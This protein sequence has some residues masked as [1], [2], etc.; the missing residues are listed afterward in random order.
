VIIHDLRIEYGGLVAQIDHLLINRFLDFYV[1]ETK[2][3]SQGVKVTERGEFLAVY[4]NRYVAIESPIEQNRRHI[5]VLEDFLVGESILPKRLGFTLRPRFLSYIL[6]S[7]KSRVIRP[8]AK[9]FNTDMLIKAD[10]FYRQT[11]DNLDNESLIESVGSAAK[12]ISR[13][14]LREVGERITGFHQPIAPDYYSK[15]GVSQVQDTQVPAPKLDR[16]PSTEVMQSKYY[17]FKC[18]CNISAKVASFCFGH[19][20]RFKG[21]AY[22]FECQKLFAR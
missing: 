2:H 7:P 19:K 18:R 4:R 12:I 20:N 6:F 22:C 11:R 9:A 14:S 1:L 13:E 8:K 3:Y 16:R 17:C 15:F 10:E 5:K 21:K